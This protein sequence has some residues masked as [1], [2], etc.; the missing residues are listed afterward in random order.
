M[1]VL[2]LHLQFQDLLNW[3]KELVIRK[4]PSRFYS[5]RLCCRNQIRR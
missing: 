4:F 5:S 3:A 1:L 2:S